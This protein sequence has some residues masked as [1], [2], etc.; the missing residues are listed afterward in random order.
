M[1]IAAG[2]LGAIGVIFGAFG[3]HSLKARISVESLEIWKTGA[4]Y[5]MFHV[6]ALLGLAA[7]PKADRFRVTAILW[8]VGVFIFSGSLYALALS[9][10]KWLGAITPLGG[11]ALISGWVLLALRA[12]KESPAE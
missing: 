7:Q 4:L 6:L 9:G 10:V 12:G 8:I 1:R 5:Q 2:V 11:L 3:A